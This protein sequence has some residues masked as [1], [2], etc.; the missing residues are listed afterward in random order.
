MTRAEFEQKM[1]KEKLEAIEK[2]N[3]RLNA[4]CTAEELKIFEQKVLEKFKYELPEEY[5]KFL[6]VVNGLEFNGLILYG[7]DE[8][9]L[10][11]KN[12]QTVT[13]YIDSNEIW[14]ENEWQKE[15]MFFGD[16][17]ISW[18]CLDVSKNVFVEL[19]KPSGSLMQEFENFEDMLE[20]AL[21]NCLA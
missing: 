13:G 12:A 5:I 7:I 14:Y 20:Y 8:S 3:G 6:S 21:G 10:D 1:L 18:Y 4:G 17:D 15:Y 16:A 11:R 19:D 9:I 2:E